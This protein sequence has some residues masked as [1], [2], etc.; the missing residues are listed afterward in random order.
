MRLLQASGQEHLSG[1]MGLDH[2]TALGCYMNFL[3]TP[4]PETLATVRA[5]G[6]FCLVGLVVVKLVGW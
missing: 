6:L 3:F 2:W 4:R 1:S 5:H